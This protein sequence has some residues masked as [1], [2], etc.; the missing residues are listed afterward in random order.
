MQQLKD[1]MHPLA[2]TKIIDGERYFNFWCIASMFVQQV[3][4]G[5]EVVTNVVCDMLLS[6]GS[7]QSQVFRLIQ[8]IKEGNLASIKQAQAMLE[9]SLSTEQM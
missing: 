6:N 4:V 7:D 3:H 9:F 2:E 8:D 1:T 5:E